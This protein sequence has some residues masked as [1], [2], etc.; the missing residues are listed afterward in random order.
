[1]TQVVNDIWK[2]D[3]NIIIKL[4]PEYAQYCTDMTAKTEEVKHMLNEQ[5]IEMAQGFDEGMQTPYGS[6]IGDEEELDILREVS[7]KSGGNENRLGLAQ[8]APLHTVLSDNEKKDSVWVL[9]GEIL[10]KNDH[11]GIAFPG[12]PLL[13]PPKRVLDVGSE[14]WFGSYLKYKF[15]SPETKERDIVTVTKQSISI[16]ADKVVLTKA[17]YRFDRVKNYMSDMKS[18]LEFITFSEKTKGIFWTRYTPNKASKRG[19]RYYR[20]TSRIGMRL[21]SSMVTM[22]RVPKRML[23]QFVEELKKRAIRDFGHDVVIPNNSQKQAYIQDSHYMRHG[24]SN[25][26]AWIITALVW[27]W[28]AKKPLRWV[29]NSVFI[30]N[31]SL[32]TAPG[33]FKSSEPESIRDEI[34]NTSDGESKHRK[35]ILARI[36]KAVRN[37]NSPK[38][39]TK[40]ILGNI[41]KDLYHKMLDTYLLEGPTSALSIVN[42]EHLINEKQI[43][44]SV[45]HLFSAA[46]NGRE[47]TFGMFRSLST[48]LGNMHHGRYTG[49][50]DVVEKYVTFNRRMMENNNDPA[51]FAQFR[52][53]LDMSKQL[54]LRL[55]LNK[56]DTWNH[57]R[58]RHDQLSEFVRRDTYSLYHTP[59]FLPFDH[60][61][62]LYGDRFEFVH[63]DTAEALVDESTQMKNCVSGY[64]YKCFGGR[65]IIFSMRHNRSWI[66][67][68]L[69]GTSNDMDILQKY[70]IGDS[71]INN[72]EIN[73]L[74]DDWHRDIRL[75]HS[76]DKVSYQ[77]IAEFAGEYIKWSSK[78]TKYAGDNLENV[79]HDERELIESTLRQA[80]LQLVSIK[81]QVNKSGVNYEEFINYI[82]RFEQKVQEIEHPQAV[83]TPPVANNEVALDGLRTQI[84]QIAEAISY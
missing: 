65:S 76:T 12:V 53:T 29:N 83:E 27:Q 31:L 45:Y 33:W 32:L 62:K 50:Y 14:V 70:T 74:I 67:I 35:K 43:P 73:N 71:D 80:G 40:A 8:E 77:N 30:E 25:L 22:S 49:G 23:A 13:A 17:A 68:E 10:D 60:P 61:K 48:T 18:D 28:K 58:R 51:P 47:D 41:Y 79:E 57:L 39:V 7:G 34:D 5:E 2:F 38:A 4:D 15:I 64:S 52:D 36:H 9:D 3:W 66:T 75:M 37:S 1:M 11:A 55:R 59:L 46:F 78:Q 63:L 20:L 81:D 84:T 44:K 54:S 42:M 21:E 19:R 69:D 16:R 6:L 24:D 82:N 26:D 72:G 56:Y